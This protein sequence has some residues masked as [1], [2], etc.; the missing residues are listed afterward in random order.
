MARKPGDIV[1]IYE[2]PWTEKTPEGEAKLIEQIVDEDEREQ[3]LVEFT[4]DH[5]KHT[6]WIKKHEIAGM[7]KAQWDSLP[8][9][10]RE[11]ELRKRGL[12][13]EFASVSFDELPEPIEIEL[14]YPKQVQRARAR[15]HGSEP[16]KKTDL[17]KEIELLSMEMGVSGKLAHYDLP[18]MSIESLRNLLLDMKKELESSHHSKP[19]NPGLR[20]WFKPLYPW[21]ERFA[22]ALAR[23][24]IAKGRFDRSNETELTQK[25]GKMLEDYQREWGESSEDSSTPKGSISDRLQYFIDEETKGIADYEENLLPELKKVQPTGGAF[26]VVWRIV[27]E[28]R[29]HREALRRIKELLSP[30]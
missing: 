12:S 8:R 10:E 1:T 28:E 18:A 7:S 30:S 3:W 11:N 25:I 24:I 20:T 4:S 6:R 15:L 9:Q 17:I 21:K 19:G 14:V 27:Q 29:R 26:T 22:D 2:D 13:T 23:D 5:A 16:L